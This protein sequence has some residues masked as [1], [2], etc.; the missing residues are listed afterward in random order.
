MKN[1]D[2]T[3]CWKKC[4]KMRT[5]I[6]V[7]SE[8]GAASLKDNLSISILATEILNTNISFKISKEKYLHVGKNTSRNYSFQNLLNL[9]LDK[10]W[11]YTDTKLSK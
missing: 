5:I 6:S 2:N 10:I 9:I 1:I 7:L 8:N 11:M 4:R 3:S